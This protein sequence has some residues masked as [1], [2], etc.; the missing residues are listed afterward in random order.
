MLID[1]NNI[2]KNSRDKIYDLLMTFFFLFKVEY[3]KWST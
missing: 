2:K 1:N 3:N